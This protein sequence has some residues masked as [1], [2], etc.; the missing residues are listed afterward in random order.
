MVRNRDKLYLWLWRTS[1][2]AAPGYT[3]DRVIANF[4]LL[5]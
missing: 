1:V 2:M 3:A 4:V 5:L